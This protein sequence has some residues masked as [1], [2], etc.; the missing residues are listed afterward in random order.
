MRH[1]MLTPN[2]LAVA[3]LVTF[4]AGC[5]G[6]SSQTPAIS[7]SATTLRPLAT[8][9]SHGFMKA[10]GARTQLVYMSSWGTASVVD[11]LTMNGE[12]VGQITSGLVEPQGLFVDAKGSLWVANFSNVLVYPRGGLS[13]ST[14]LSDPV[15]Y[16]GDVTVCPDGTAY[17]ADFYN[18]SNSGAA[19]IQVYAHGSATPTGNLDYANDFRN[20]FLTCD[21][22]GNV[23]VALLTG[24]SVGDGLVVEFPHGK[25]KGAKS[26]GIVLQSPGG[27]KPDNAGNLLVTDLIG[28]TITEYA[29]NGSPTGRSIATGAATEGIAVSRNGRIVLGATAADTTQQGPVGISWSFPGGKQLRVYT[30]CSRIGPPLQVNEGVAFYPGQKGI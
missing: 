14:T 23:F 20:P 21:A 17:V 7:G 12:Q 25:Q 1:S 30:C 22:A 5:S 10:V 9:T 24:E 11:V 3:A 15:G 6:G 26:L 4:L 28:H 18:Y 27:I 13:P 19:S 29:E 8:N 16:P 2:A